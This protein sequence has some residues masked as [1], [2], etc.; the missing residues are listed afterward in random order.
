MS[1][2]PSLIASLFAS[3]LA[4]AGPAGADDARRPN[5]LVILSDDVG[6]GE[7][8]FQGGKDIPTPHIDSIARNGVRFTQGYVSGP[9]LQPDPGRPDDGPLPDPVRPR[10]QSRA[11]RQRPAP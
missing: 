6:W 9:V 8:G 1:T 4:W 5:I 2:R 11:G 10:E 3:S 7:Y